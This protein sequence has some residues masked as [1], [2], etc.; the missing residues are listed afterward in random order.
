MA[1]YNASNK[2]TK[3]MRNK[4]KFSYGLFVA[5]LVPFLAIT[6]VFAESGTDSDVSE[7]EDVNNSANLAQ[8]G[9][10]ERMD[11][12]S[13]AEKKMMEERL[14]QRGEVAQ[15]TSD[16]GAMKERMEKRM[17]R[18]NMIQR[19]MQ[20]QVNRGLKAV[21]RLEQ[22]LLRVESRRAKLSADGTDVATIDTM[23]AD[24]KKQLTEAKTALAKVM[25]APEDVE[26][27][28]VT[29]EE[30]A[31]NSGTGS[32]E[33]NSGPGSGVEEIQMTVR[34]FMASMKVLKKELVD[35]HRGLKAIVK[36][37]RRVAPK[38]DQDEGTTPTTEPAPTP[39]PEPTPTPSPTSTQ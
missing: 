27:A 1:W 35:V 10:Q 6:M 34:E 31:D 38:G 16:M 17:E 2:L 25:G 39:T 28:D 13:R 29:E 9:M 4:I 3:I 8:D 15:M 11:E 20:V 5:L 22:V 14:K 32:E 18:K 36:E 30:D 37:M 26:E 21:A 12:R 23:I 7:I 24:V 33:D 19:L